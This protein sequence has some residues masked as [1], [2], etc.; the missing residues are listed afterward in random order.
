M[1]PRSKHSASADL[2]RCHPL[3]PLSYGRAAAIVRVWSKATAPQCGPQG[4]G[5]GWRER[6]LIY[7]VVD[8]SEAPSFIDEVLNVWPAMSSN[9]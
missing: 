6:P 3:C 2:V 1:C 8:G 4:H 9:F 5:A 7:N